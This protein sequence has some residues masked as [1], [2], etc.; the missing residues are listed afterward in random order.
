MLA[1]RIRRGLEGSLV[2]L[3]AVV[4]TRAS[5]REVLI[6]HAEQ[7]GPLAFPRIGAIKGRAGRREC[8]VGREATPFRSKRV[9]HEPVVVD[10]TARRQLQLLTQ[11]LQV[12]SSGVTH[13]LTA[14]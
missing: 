9:L 6:A 12:A 13:G 8:G 11:R 3:G 4:G 2:T 10:R 1:Q 7:P 14:S 5:R